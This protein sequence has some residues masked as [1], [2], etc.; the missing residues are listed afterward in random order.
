[1]PSRLERAQE[2]AAI[3]AKKI[4]ELET[5]STKLLDRLIEADNKTVISAYEARIS[6]LEQEK[7]LLAE[8]AAQTG[9]PRAAFEQMFEL[10]AAFPATFVKSGKQGASTCNDSC[11]N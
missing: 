1:M 5:Q 10:A 8:K 9:Q 3:Y 7:L 4:R 6:K 11:S 2:Q